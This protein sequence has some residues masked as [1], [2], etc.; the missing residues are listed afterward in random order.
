MTLSRF[1]LRS[2]HYHSQRLETELTKMKIKI[3]PALQ[4]N[5]MYLLVDK[6]T[7][8][9]AVIDPVEPNKVITAVNEE[10]VKLTT[11]LTTHHH[12]D[13]AGG[14]LD[15][16]EKIKGLSVFGGDKRIDALTKTVNHDHTFKL[17]SL[18]IRCLH[19][20]CHTTGHI[21]YFVEEEGEDP[22]VFTGDT[23]F[24][25]GCGKFF[26]GEPSHMYKALVDILGNLPPNT[27]VY[28]GHEYTVSNLK[29]ALHVEPD[30]ASIQE[31]LKW[32][33]EQ[34]SNKKPTI[35]STIKEEKEYNPFMRVDI[36]LMQNRCQT[37]TG[38]ETM[39]FLRNEK[40]NFKAKY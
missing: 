12:L 28:C 17:G 4:D 26:E 22:V 25:G 19:T 9:A 36:D 2:L 8:Q 6:K 14:N 23:L 16:S 13:H 30:N 38:E 21:C 31:K 10:E 32:A 33:Q 40:D 27:K 18:S 24:I 5:Y 7:N 3:L 37:E 34:R 29:Y 20:P 1:I 35:P 39:G 11:V 15:L